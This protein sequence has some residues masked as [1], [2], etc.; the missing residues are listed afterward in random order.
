MQKV[1]LHKV[2][3]HLLPEVFNS[4]LEDNMAEML[5]GEYKFQMGW[6]WMQT[7]VTLNIY[8]SANYNILRFILR[9]LVGY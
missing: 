1:T 5:Q 7:T 2:V 9:D 4:Q 8:D 6:R 3:S